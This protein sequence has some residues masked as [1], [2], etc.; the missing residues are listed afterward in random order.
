[1]IEVIPVGTRI[2]AA[3]MQAAAVRVEGFAIVSLAALAPAVQVSFVVMMVSE[4]PP[5]EYIHLSCR[6]VHGYYHRADK[7]VHCHLAFDSGS[8]RYKCLR[9]AIVGNLQS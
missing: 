8:A 6:M 2:L 1:M 9:G 7:A 5:F 4:I 3:L